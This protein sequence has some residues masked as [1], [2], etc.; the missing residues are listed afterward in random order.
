MI[1]LL[2]PGKSRDVPALLE[3]EAES[4]AG[5]NWNARDFARYDTLVAELDGTIIGFLVSRQTFAGGR[6]GLPE[7]EILNVAVARQFRRHGIATLLLRHA[8]ASRAIYF[9]EVRESNLGAQALYR[10]LGFVEV[11]RRPKYYAHPEESAIVM[12][13]K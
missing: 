8:L 11:G 5:P 9:L 13:L 7:R 2:R 4:F 10:R 6:D 12:Q 3:I 1:P